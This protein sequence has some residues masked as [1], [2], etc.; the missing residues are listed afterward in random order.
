MKKRSAF[1]LCVMLMVC[2]T[3]ITSGS[4]AC[5]AP[6]IAA[7]AAATAEVE[8]GRILF[9]KN[10]DRQLPMASTT[11][12]MTAVLAVESGRLD[13]VVTI[14]REAA[15]VEGSSIYLKAG[16]KFTL[17]HLVY[18][19]MLRS[20]N[21]AAE[22]IAI[23]LAGDV[24]SFV[25][26]MNEK[27]KEI[28][29]SHTQF[30]NPH[31]LP[32]D[33]HYTTANDLARIAAYGMRNE[34]FATIVGTKSMTMEPQGAGERRTIENKNKLLWNLEGGIGIK[35]GYTKAAGKCLVGAVENDTARVVSVVLNDQSMWDDSI[36][37]LNTSLKQLKKTDI[38][39]IG[40]VAGRVPV[41][42]AVDQQTQ[43]EAVTTD[44]FSFALMESE[45][46]KIDVQYDLYT[47]VQAPVAQ[48][49]PLGTC[50]ITFDG[51]IVY[52]G[53]VVANQ[54]IKAD[55]WSDRL[56]KVINGWIS[57]AS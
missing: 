42:G 48:G 15:G 1:L 20:G 38:L 37:W 21:D 18:G 7:E 45:K 32:A 16:E 35:T 24:P 41:S 22:A 28:G 46:E 50:T 39:S 56:R 27:A 47:G 30:Q 51:Q 53:D 40:T 4:A 25:K 36:L 19:L 10:G 8:T 6:E 52:Q 57:L 31:G 5:A 55:T 34:T 26:Q 12:I 14:P 11:K 33:G 17:E 54:S 23:F 49:D 9:S 3:W 43:V 13:E 2:T 44:S 29:A